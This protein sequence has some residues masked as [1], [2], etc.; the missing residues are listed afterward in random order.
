MNYFSETNPHFGKDPFEKLVH[1]IELKRV[2][3]DPCGHNFFKK[4]QL[5]R[6]KLPSLT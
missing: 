2:R 4:T 5:G 6:G 1:F 3:G